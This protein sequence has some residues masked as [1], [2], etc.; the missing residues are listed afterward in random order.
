MD[1]KN[2]TLM[3]LVSSILHIEKVIEGSFL[4]PTKL[5][6]KKKIILAILELFIALTTNQKN[7]ELQCP[8]TAVSYAT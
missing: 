5:Q 6:K 1:L 7:S 2:V 8:L 3:T 4:F